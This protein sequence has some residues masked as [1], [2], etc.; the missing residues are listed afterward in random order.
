MCC[1][2]L[3]VFICLTGS[4]LAVSADLKIRAEMAFVGYGKAI[5]V[6]PLAVTLKNTG[7]DARG[8]LR[9]SSGGFQMDYPVEL[10]RGAVKRLMTYPQVEYAQEISLDL[11]TNQGS[12]H[13]TFQ[14]MFTDDP[15][16]QNVLLIGD[17]EGDLAFLKPKGGQ[18]VWRMKDSYILPELAPDRLIA[19]SELSG[20]VLGIGA[21]RLTD[22]AVRALHSYVLTGGTVVFL[23]GASSPIISDPRWADVLPVRPGKPVTVASSALLA[24]LSPTPV[25]SSFAV[26]SCVAH[27]EASTRSE[28]GIVVLA[29][30]DW[31]LGKAVFLAFNPIEPPFT[32]WPGRRALFEK[33]IRP[34]E[35]VRALEYLKGFS[36]SSSRYENPYYS[37]VSRYAT[38]ATTT[39]GAGIAYSPIQV[40]EQQAAADPFNTKLPAAN[41]V[42][43]I[44]AS[45][46]I[47][48]IPI[49][50][51]LLKKLKR[52]ELAWFTAPIISIGFAGAFFAAAKDLYSAKLS[53]AT[54]GLIV[55][56]S[57]AD[58]V[59]VGRSQLFFPR[60]GE[61]DL[62]MEGLES[63]GSSPSDEDYYGGYRSRQQAGLS[64]VNPIDVGHIL[65]SRMDVTNLAFRELGYRQML[66][67]SKWLTVALN[68]RKLTIRNMCSHELTGVSAVVAGKGIPLEKPLG[69]GSAVTLVLPSQ[70]VPDPVP[71]Q[72]RNEY[73]YSYGQS[74]VVKYSGL[75]E[76]TL[77]T[78]GI[79][80][81]ANVPEAEVGPRIGNTVESRQN[82][83]LAYFTGLRYGKVQL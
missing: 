49:N 28:R 15:N 27:G 35:S 24:A 56:T 76:L 73:G 47:V 58:S 21:E 62:R 36:G 83:V 50:F 41:K 14:Q 7:P 60:G 29:R 39:G 57:G 66:P 22:G 63:V 4:C 55:A 80:I 1:K 8:S 3:S 10:P 33:V 64:D 45:Y 37:S 38:P 65:V 79:V 42:F 23:G 25:G 11:S 40:M 2:L 18:Q 17:G 20:V 31:G 72:Q 69:P 34:M 71:E 48:I 52:G 46:F 12:L 70:I 75:A 13:G 16:S 54:Q 30:K 61:Y 26:L 68:G 81:R 82:V 59:F 32:R 5:G 6:L 67:S 51:L 74:P 53:T 44:L 19:Y 78:K 77:A 9:V 43:L